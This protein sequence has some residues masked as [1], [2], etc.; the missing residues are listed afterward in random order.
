MLAHALM[1]QGTKMKILKTQI[2][3]HKMSELSFHLY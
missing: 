2:V 3:T 1:I